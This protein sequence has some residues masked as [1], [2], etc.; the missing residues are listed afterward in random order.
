MI[1]RPA[2]VPNVNDLER[3]LRTTS[4]RF[5]VRDEMVAREFLD[6]FDRQVAELEKR[7]SE[8]QG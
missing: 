1:N 7:P 4:R 2:R 3:L 8:D 5:A 6:D